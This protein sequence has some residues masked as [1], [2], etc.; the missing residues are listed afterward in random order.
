ML[1]TRFQPIDPSHWVVL[2]NAR[3]V[4]VVASTKDGLSAAFTR[5]PLAR[6]EVAVIHEFMAYRAARAGTRAPIV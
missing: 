4:A 5:R 6:Q 3:K 1:Y 2:S